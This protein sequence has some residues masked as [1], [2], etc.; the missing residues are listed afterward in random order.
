MHNLAHA[1]PARAH[2]AHVQSST[3]PL[4]HGET[5]ANDS[6]TRTGRQM[7]FL[8]IIADLQIGV[9]QIGVGQIGVGQIGAGEP[10]SCGQVQRCW[11]E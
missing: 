6:D 8:Q 11:D 2:L 5:T 10:A 3:V 7:N 9:G 4:C 1:H